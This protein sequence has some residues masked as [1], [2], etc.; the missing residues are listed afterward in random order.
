MVKL[1]HV[2]IVSICLATMSAWGMDHNMENL[3]WKGARLH[4]TAPIDISMPGH[5]GGLNPKYFIPTHSHS[6]PVKSFVPPLSTTSPKASAYPVKKSTS[7]ARGLG[8]AR[9][10]TSLS[11]IPKPAAP[12]ALINCPSCNTSLAA[13]LVLSKVATPEKK[14][15]F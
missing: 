9:R 5:F 8:D 2:G 10:S 7:P 1:F 13:A 6:A 15:H 14:S 12:I 4:A 3:S 11:E